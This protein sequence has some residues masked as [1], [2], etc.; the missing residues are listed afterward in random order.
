MTCVPNS[1]REFVKF[2]ER[3]LFDKQ[4]QT[5]QLWSGTHD[6]TQLSSSETRKLPLVPSLMVK[7]MDPSQR[8]L[9]L[10]PNGFEMKQL[11][12]TLLIPRRQVQQ[13]NALLSYAGHQ[14]LLLTPRPFLLLL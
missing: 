7:W 12:S 1:F 11:T 2:F 13:A 4:A 5:Q 10:L 9:L 8:R 14:P 3:I 6:L